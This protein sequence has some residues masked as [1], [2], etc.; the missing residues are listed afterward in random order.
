MHIPSPT[1]PAPRW[2]PTALRLTHYYTVRLQHEPDV[3]GGPHGAAHRHG[4]GPPAGDRG[5]RIRS[6]GGPRGRSEST[7]EAPR[8]S[9][10]P[11]GADAADAADALVEATQDACPREARAGGAGGVASASA[12][13]GGGGLAGDEALQQVGGLLGDGIGNGGGES[14][15]EEAGGHQLS[16]AL[17]DVLLQDQ[18]HGDVL[19]HLME[20]GEI[21][22]ECTVKSVY[23]SN[24]TDRDLSADGYGCSCASDGKGAHNHNTPELDIL[25]V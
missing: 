25:I 11:R 3:R 9:A 24:V 14:V 1:P 10:E 7:A 20:A 17:A 2:L 6:Q 13:G 19:H 15:Q 21:R 12:F 22:R 18:A 8:R 4:Q 5:D 16:P 23:N